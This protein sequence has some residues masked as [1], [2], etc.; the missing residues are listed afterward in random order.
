MNWYANKDRSLYNLTDNGKTVVI[1]K[2]RSEESDWF[3]QITRPGDIVA[4]S[5]RTKRLAS[6]WLVSY[7]FLLPLPEEELERTK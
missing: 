6:A 1:L 7:Y 3:V 2:W 5:F 4:T